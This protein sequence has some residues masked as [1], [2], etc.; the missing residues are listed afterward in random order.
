MR[1][2]GWGEGIRVCKGERED[3]NM[4]CLAT[5]CILVLGLFSIVA[6][7]TVSH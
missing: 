1:G 2:E 5:M 7:M 3:D 4:K 6:F